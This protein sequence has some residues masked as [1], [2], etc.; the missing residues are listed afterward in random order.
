M[1]TTKTLPAVKHCFAH[2]HCGRG[3]CCYGSPS[4]EDSSIR[5]AFLGMQILHVQF[6]TAAASAAHLS[7][8]HSSLTAE[9]AAAAMAAVLEAAVVLVAA[10]CCHWRR[11]FMS[12][13]QHWSIC[14]HWQLCL[15]AQGIEGASASAA[16][17]AV[18]QVLHAIGIRSATSPYRR[19]ATNLH[20]VLL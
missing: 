2:C 11:L 5:M 14:S 17:A 16:A 18:L 1:V 15:C 19:P 13:H 6:P 12:V 9:P 4:R 7:G 3:C 10:A 8:S 20:A